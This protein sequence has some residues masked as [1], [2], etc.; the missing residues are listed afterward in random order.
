LLSSVIFHG[1]FLINSI[2]FGCVLV[3]AFLIFVLW[4]ISNLGLLK[5]T[6]IAIWQPM[7]VLAMLIV[8]IFLGN[9]DNSLKFG[10]LPMIVK[11]LVANFILL[12]SIY[13]FVKVIE[14]PLRKNLGV[15]LLNLVSLFISHLNEGTNS[16]EKIFEEIGE[17]IDT[18]VGILSFKTNDRIKALFISPCVHPGP[19]GDIGGSNMP[20]ILANSFDNFTMVV[21][22]P[23]THDFNPVST[24][25]LEKLKSA[26]KKGIE[27]LNYGDE[28]SKFVRYSQKGVN[29]G[30]QYFNDSMVLLTTLAPYGSDDIEFG[31]GLSMMI[32]S[33]KQCNVKNSIVVDCHNSFNAEI[34]RILPGNPEVFQILDTIDEINCEEL[35]SDIKVGCSEKTDIENLDKSNGIGQSGIKVMVVEVS[36][37]RTAY[38]LLDSNNME[39]GFRERIFKELKKLAIDEA[40]VMTTD[41]HYV[42]TLSNGYNPVGLSKKEDIIN[43]IKELVN[44]AIDDIEIV[45]AGACV[46][47]IEGLKT[48][49]PNNSTEL[50]ST[51]SSILAVSKIMAPIIFILAI[52]FVFIWIFLY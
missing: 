3:F 42:N 46:E 51:I 15:G 36:G 29:I 40:E 20:T 17:P 9:V 45:E 47:K 41:T 6:F 52:L 24:K 38:I 19:I 10:I 14:S 33:K 5:S 8:T 23:S 1:D 28:G 26:V 35:I 27:N 31:V 30:I 22:G 32:Q 50:I 4:S 16:L 39:I 43:L 34:G 37:Q 7:V 2:L 48:F 25:E 11:F 44:E 18:L 13:S 12:L 49:G 21:H